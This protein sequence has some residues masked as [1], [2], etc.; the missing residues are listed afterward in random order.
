MKAVGITHQDAGQ[1]IEV[2]CA[3]C[4]NHQCQPPAFVT[5]GRP[6]QAGYDE[7]ENRMS[8]WTRHREVP[9]E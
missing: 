7:C 6:A 1:K 9:G 2:G 8:N 5:I 3:P 4:K